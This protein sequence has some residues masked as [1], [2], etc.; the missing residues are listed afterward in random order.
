RGFRIELGEI[1]SRLLKHEDIKEAVVIERNM[2]NGDLYLCAYIVPRVPQSGVNTVDLKV[3][4]L[5][6]FLSQELPDYMIPSYFVSLS[7]IPLT[8]NGKIDHSRLAEPEVK[9]EKDHKLPRNETEKNLAEVWQKVLELEK[10]GIEDNFFDLG[11]DSIKAIR[12]ISRINER[13]NNNLKIIDLYTNST[14]AKLADLIK[15][16]ES[17][18]LQSLYNEIATDFEELKD[19]VLVQM[20]EQDKWNLDEIEDIY[21]MSEIEKGMVFNYLKYA[22]LGI[23]HDQF[24]LPLYYKD[25]DIEIFQKAL[26][27]LVKKNEILRTAFNLDEFEEPIQIVY[28]EPILNL[29]H[30]NLKALARKEQ[31]DWI[32]DWLLEERRKPFGYSAYPLWR[33]HIITFENDRLYMVLTFHH[34]ILDGWSTSL[35]LT[36]LH[37]TY[38]ELKKNIHF[39]PIKLKASYKDAVIEERIE[40]ENICAVKYWQEELRDY[41]RLEF[42]ETLKNK[43]ELELMKVYR[44]NAG[45]EILAKARNIAIEWNTSIKN[46]FFSAYAYMMR[47]FSYENDMVLGCVTNNRP[48][49]LDGDNILGCFLNTVPVRLSIPASLSWKEYA[50]MVE[51]KMLEVKQHDRFPLFEIALAIGE[52]GKDRNPIFDTLFN[53][54][55]FHSYRQL[56]MEESD[57]SNKR[58]NGTT[59]K[60]NNSP[61]IEG[62]FDT[63][64]LFD[65]ELDITS[66]SLLI[67][68]KYNAQVI[69]HEM[70]KKYCVYFVNILEKYI[71]SSDTLACRN[72]ILPLAEKE[73]LLYHFNNTTAPYSREKTMH[74]LFE[75]QVFKTQDNTA[76]IDVDGLGHLTYRELNERANQLAQ[77]L[78]KIGVKKNDFVG[79]VMERCME[80]VLAVMGILKA[81]GAYVPL[82][83]YLPERRIGKILGSLQTTCVITDASAQSRLASMNVY[84]V[85]LDKGVFENFKNNPRENPVPLVN[86]EDISYVIYTSGSTGIPKGVVETHRPVVNVI[87]WVNNIFSVGKTDKLLF[88][89]SLGFDLSVYDIFGILASGGAIR[90]AGSVDMKEPLKLLEIIVKEGITFWDSAPAA[91]QQLVPFFNEIKEAGEITVLRLIFLSGDWIPVSMPDALRNTFKG[92]QVISLGGATEATIWSNYYTIG[93]VDPAWPSIPYGKPIQN[94]KYYIL[95]TCLDLC[96]IEI[97]GDLYI[98]GECL[99]NE[100]KNDAELTAAKFITNPFCAGET[101]EKMYKTGDIARWL[102]D[103]NMQFLGRKD[104][105][106]KIRGYR[107]E[108]GEIESQLASFPGIREAIVID[109]KDSSGNKYICAYYT[110]K[111]AGEKIAKEELQSYLSGELPEY[112][113]PSHFIAID[114]VPVTPNGKLDRKALPVPELLAEKSYV[115]PGNDLQ[116]KLVGI[117]QEVLFGYKVNNKKTAISIDDNFFELGGHSLN[118]TIVIAKIHK[119]L[120]VKVPLA[121]MFRHPTIRELAKIIGKSN[122]EK[123]AEIKAVEKKEYYLLSSAQKRLYI[124]QQLDLESTAYN[125]PDVIPLAKGSNFEKIEEAFIKLIMRHESLR[126]S[127]HMVNEILVQKIHEHVP[128][129]IEK[130]ELREKENFSEV[131]GPTFFQKGR[132]Q[133]AIQSFI[134]PFDLSKAPLLRVGLMNNIL[135]VDMH[136]II[137]DGISREVLVKDYQALYNEEKILP[138]LLQYKDFSEWQNSESERENL[139]RQEEFWLKE[140]SGEIPVLELPINYPRPR[141][142]SFEGNSIKFGLSVEETRG[143]N[144]LAQQ[145]G[146]TLFMILIAVFNILLTKLSG[147]EEIIIGTPIAARRHVDLE[148]IIGMFVNT[149]SLRNCP[150]EMQTFKEFLNDVKERAL[151][152][153]EN[154]EYPFEELVDKLLLRRD[155]GRNPLF[156]VMFVLQNMNM[157]LTG[158]KEHKQEI[159]ATNEYE[160]IFRIAKF[161]LTLTVKEINQGLILIFEYCSKLFKKET[162]EQ[163]IIYFKKIAANIVQ[164]P[165]V[166]I[167]DIEIITEAEKKQILF[168]FNDTRAEYPKDKNIHQ[169]F[170]EQVL[171]TPGHISIAGESIIEASR[172]RSLQIS[173]LQLKEQSDKLA[174]LLIEKGVQVDN[175]VGIMMNRSIEMIIG[176]LGI[177]K[178]GG[179]YL[180]IDSVY[181]AARKKYMIKDG[182]IRWLLVNHDIEDIA[183]EVI[184]RLDVI[185]LRQKGNFVK[186][187]VRLEYAGGGSSLVYVIYTSGSTGF[188]KGVMLEH[189]NL[190][191]LIKFQFNNTNID[192]SRILQFSTISFDASFH[193][194]FSALLSGGQLFLI[195]KETQ[196]DIPGLFKLI[197]R[198][199]IKTVFLP[200]SFL[201]MIFKE[202]EY[203]NLVP[204]CIRHIQT[205]GEQVIV[206]DNFKKYLKERK[207]YLHNHY[208]PSETHVVTTLTIDPEGEIPELPS[209]GKP[210]TNTKIYIVNKWGYL[211]PLGIAGEILIGGVQVGRGYLNRP[212]LTAEKFNQDESY[213][214]RANFHHSSLTIHPSKLYC[215]GDLARWLP[216]GNIEFLGRI[217]YQ[218]KI[219]GFRIELGEIEKRL[220][221]HPGIKEAVVLM[222]DEEDKYLCAYI[223]SDHE[224]G[225][226]ELREYL[227]SKLPDYMIPAYFVTLT[228]IPLTVNGKID[229]KSLPKPGLKV[230]E[231]YTPPRNKLEKKLVELWSEVL[232]KNKLNSSQLQL[233]IGIDDNFFNLGGHSLKA[234]ILISKIHKALNVFVP[235]AEVFKNATIRGLAEYIRSKVEEEYESIQPV[236]K[237]EYYE[238]SSAQ[239]RLY[240]LQQLEADNVAYNIPLIISLPKEIQIE[241]LTEVFKQ[242]LKRH[243][244]LRTSFQ[245]LDDMPIQKIHDNV[246]FKIKRFEMDDNGRNDGHE[247]QE[248]YSSFIRPFDLS[249]APLLRIGFLKKRDEVILLIDIHHIITDGTSQEVLREDFMSLYREEKLPYLQLQYKDFVEWKNSNK[250]REKLKEQELYWL[251]EF[252]GEIPVLR[253]PTDYV[254]PVVQ[255][256]AGNSLSFKIGIEETRSLNE[257]A[258]REGATLFMVLAGVLNILLTKLSGQED[259]AMGVPVAGRRHADLEKIIG[260]FVNTLA[261][262]N[263][264]CGEKSFLV[265]LNELKDR[266]LSAFEN[267][268]YQFEDLVEKVVSQ[269]DMSRNPLFDIL[270]AVQNVKR[271]PAARFEKDKT[272]ET[273]EKEKDDDVIQVSKFDLEINA[274][275]V[276]EEIKIIFIYC[277]KLFKQE[278]IERFIIYFKKI[279]AIIIQRPAIRIKDIEIITDEEKEQILNAFNQTAAIYPKNKTVPQLFAEQVEQTPDYIALVGAVEGEAKKRSGEEEK[280][281]DL[282]TLRATSLQIQMSYRQLNEQCNQLAGSLIEKGVLPGNIIGIKMERSVEMVIA[283]IGVLK[284]GGTYLPIDPDYPQ[285]RI[286]YMLKDSNAKVLINKSEARTSKYETNPNVQKINDQNKN[287]EGLTVLNLNHLDFEFVSNFGFRNSDLNSSNL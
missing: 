171:K 141:I 50:V 139:K 195:N 108:L 118:A 107:I 92:V 164:K 148:K 145:Q 10:I 127:F 246:E 6:E 189:H 277:T 57:K 33:I 226:S 125:I 210:V 82:E 250:E 45:M 68:P 219:R 184:N 71:N 280:N 123:Y 146:A 100:Y 46:L 62:Q 131:S 182:K 272:S 4:S 177:I 239:K 27:M 13:L 151:L 230:N 233:T 88:V 209:I 264:P 23:Y 183:D 225:V 52:K 156:D 43:E 49:K 147:Q 154:Q 31:I 251:N 228:K 197:A 24:V 167:K 142:Q 97:A 190:V 159:V 185:D 255:S 53:F 76:I 172:S 85:I 253:I 163:F 274:W 111:R 8:A 281:S 19:R 168:D 72:E 51:Q 140:F 198:N 240:F 205:A 38:F 28:K 89:A 26:T 69:S 34:A 112:M 105:Q 48:V 63:N 149:L 16:D 150:Q 7:E 187:N 74:Q 120:N 196:T 90:T 14:I 55:D 232:G 64:T 199:S 135:L 257:M 65:F 269:R 236:E 229:R 87:E 254:R 91:L 217:D 267:Q 83:P 44:Y 155:T 212:E 47:M 22:G 170:E 30:T 144:M 126:T 241:K 215:T 244:S 160:N 242:L 286:D 94:A 18:L 106:V 270:L 211:L 102:A 110:V 200:I 36:E 227:L 29:F 206:S 136:H 258:L 153:F 114:Q 234:T 109:Q 121:E 80:M 66:G 162:I 165:F 287:I 207:V 235:L 220:L 188:P 213:A 263:Y 95:D 279:I 78:H 93:H 116:E 77:G 67:H 276:G 130:L 5:R 252:A 101:N 271:I 75:E 40:K 218:V 285:E 42:S 175:V 138:L 245:M 247:V 193:E 266:T 98:G 11:G 73:N 248:I 223:V 21:P 202:E 143:L 181:P 9:I 261:L 268:E 122:K 12:L 203:L 59:Q 174:G 56:E 222:Q 238:L 180:P 35:F 32:K 113:L 132:Q 278:T 224:Y 194:I 96:P 103:G 275:E 265:F 2:P 134:R 201:K 70:V 256:F 39:V 104:H 54:T 117:W 243:D 25:F 192:C 169:L 231:S 128:F 84:K 191:N 262:R 214:L 86:S 17:E 20:K 61:S 99:A 158:L 41:I 157:G 79:V 178:A 133:E 260:M 221:S 173:Y 208:G 3:S 259:I 237:K 37:N 283:L 282:E 129:E 166:K 152:A 249:L 273:A 137:S 176:I 58:D 186:G 179:A 81:G 15:R 124:L 284:A 115:G 161:D 1:E 216:D 119:I 204:R 60:D